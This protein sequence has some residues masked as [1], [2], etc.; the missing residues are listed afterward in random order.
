MLIAYTVMTG[1]STLG[2]H[3]VLDAL[4]S[5]LGQ[6]VMIMAAKTWQDCMYAQ[7]CAVTRS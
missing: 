5:I 7:R 2:V 4:V 6:A 3:G 1:G